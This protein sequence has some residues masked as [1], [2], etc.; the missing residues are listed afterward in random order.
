MSANE[1]A[2]ILRVALIEP[3]MRC[4]LDALQSYAQQIEDAANEYPADSSIRAHML[5]E[6]A[7]AKSLTGILNR[8]WNNP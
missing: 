5:G 4:V 8:A 1:E 7:R 2:K 3:E 6:M